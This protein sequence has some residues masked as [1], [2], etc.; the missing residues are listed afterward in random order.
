MRM[1]TKV[2][3]VGAASVVG[4]AGLGVTV[5]GAPLAVSASESTTTENGESGFLADRLQRIKDALAGLV[6]DGTITQDQADEVAGTL[7][8]SDA[9]RGGPGGHGGTAGTAVG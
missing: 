6:G 7:A 5:A 8:E 2:A 9:L 3:A 1:R 4:L